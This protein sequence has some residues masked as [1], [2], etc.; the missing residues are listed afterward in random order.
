MKHFIY[1]FFFILCGFTSKAQPGTLDKNFGMNGIVI[2]RGNSYDYCHEVIL[3]SDGKIIQA[4]EGNCTIGYG[5]LL[6]RFNPDGS[7]DASFGNGGCVTTQISEYSTIKAV[8][9]QT[10]GKISYW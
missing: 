2:T 8:A 10:D 5:F 1:S 9:V 7:L 4:G 3:Q 6:R